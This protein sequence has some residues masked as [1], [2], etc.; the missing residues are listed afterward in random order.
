MHTQ[1]SIH[2]HA[3]VH[4]ME[5]R[6][7]IGWK[8]TSAS[9]GLSDF[10]G[11]TFTFQSM[12]TFFTFFARFLPPPHFS[13]PIH[14]YPTHHNLYP[15]YKSLKIL[16]HPPPGN[17]VTTAA[18]HKSFDSIHPYAHRSFFFPAISPQ[19]MLQAHTSHISPHRP[20]S[21]P[22]PVTG[23]IFNPGNPVNPV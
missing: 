11:C 3:T 21:C 12:E 10:H 7:S 20:C 8:L 9:N 13:P 2:R 6:T 14:L 23:P 19:T 22:L 16:I 1:T 18:S 15:T 17:G 4:R 5:A